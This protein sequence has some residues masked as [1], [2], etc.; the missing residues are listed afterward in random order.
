MNLPFVP[1]T[2]FTH[3][4]SA[5]WA[6]LEGAVDSAEI[7]DALASY[8][9]RE[10]QD[11]P[12]R[13]TRSP[14]K[15]L[16]AEVMLQR[17]HRRAVPAVWERFVTRWPTAED[18]AGAHPNS[19]RSVLRPLG[20]P[21][22][23]TQL[24]LLAQ[25]IATLDKFPADYDALRLLPG[26]GDYTARAVMCQA[27]GGEK[28]MVD[29]TSGRVL[30]RIYGFAPRTLRQSLR[31]A[32]LAAAPMAARHGPRLIALALLDFGNT[33]CTPRPKC[34]ACPLLRWCIAA[35]RPNDLARPHD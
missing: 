27:F 12:W 35:A 33:I 31:F 23:A 22:R 32:D 26:V 7:G 25:E 11:L 18:V 13:K 4:A 19:I 9:E 14:F 30:S 17:T 29:G 2:P 6:A 34:Q 24:R 28:P 16:V 8:Y 20:L 1:S 21:R 10:G 3:E 5:A 15:L